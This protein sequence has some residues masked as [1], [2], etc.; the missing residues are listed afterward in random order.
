MLSLDVVLPMR[1]SVSA[2]RRTLS[3]PGVFVSMH[4]FHKHYVILPSAREDS[5]GRWMPVVSVRSAEKRNG[6]HWS[7]PPRTMVL[8]R[9]ENRYE[10][11]QRSVEIAKQMIDCREFE[12]PRRRRT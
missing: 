4:V 8:E 9:M 2:P 1:R 7:W 10:A 6:N 11:E 12:R 5:L 3:D